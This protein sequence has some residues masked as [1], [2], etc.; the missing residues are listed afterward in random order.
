LGISAPVTSPTF[1]LVNRYRA[2]GG[3]TLQHVD[4]Y[5]LSNAALEMW[6]IGLTDLF[7][8]DDVVV[9]EWADRIAGLLPDHYLEIVF[10]Y[11]S[12]ERRWLCFT[13]HGARSRALLEQ[14]GDQVGSRTPC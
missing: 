12:E 13:A 3:I 8:D 7:A 10:T 9:I 14:L 2:P 5:R 6:D 1:T 11:L 4:C